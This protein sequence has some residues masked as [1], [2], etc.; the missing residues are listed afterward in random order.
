MLLCSA[1]HWVLSQILM[2]IIRYSLFHLGHTI[3]KFPSWDYRKVTFSDVRVFIDQTTRVDVPLEPQAIEVNEIVVVAERKLIKADVATSVAA[4]SDRE[5]E[6]LPI[7]NVVSAVGLEAGIRGGWAGSPGYAAQPSFY[8]QNYQRGSISVNG[9][10]IRGGSGDNVLYMVDGVT[11]RDPRN[12]EP[13]TSIALSAVKEIAVERSGFNA[14][15]GQVRSGIINVVTKEGA[16]RGYYGSFQGKMS[17]AAPKYWSGPGILDVN[18]P[19]SWALAAFLRSGCLLEGNDEW[20]L[21]YLY[22]KP[23][24]N[25]RW[26]ECS[27]ET[28]RYR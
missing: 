22:S 28:I 8:S 18:D 15:Y 2:E 9:P 20:R 25:V 7:S 12:S 24:C 14:E 5:I 6:A 1:H 4:I 3:S 11:Q 13:T 16:K 19:N 26:M 23:V 27:F 10:S 17:P 21:G